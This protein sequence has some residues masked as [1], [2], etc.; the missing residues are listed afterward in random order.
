VTET[1]TQTMQR[2]ARRDRINRVRRRLSQ[3]EPEDQDIIALI[4]AVKGMLDI[5]ADD[6]E[7]GG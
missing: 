7:A 3:I 1:P 2:T 4:G 6:K 5:L